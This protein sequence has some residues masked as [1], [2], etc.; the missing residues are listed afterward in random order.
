MANTGSRSGA[1]YGDA[2]ILQYVDK[3]HANHDEALQRAFDAPKQEGMPEIQLMPSEA[4][5]LAW[6]MKLVAARRVVELGTLAGYSAIQMAQSLTA[7]GKLWTIDAEPRHADV[8]RANVIAAGLSA[9]VEVL[10]GRGIDMLPTVEAHGPFDA[11][12]I[13]ADK[14]GYP[15]YGRWAQ[16][17]H[18]SGGLMIADNVFLFGE[19][20]GESDDAAAM[21]RFHEESAAAFDTACIATPDGLLVARKP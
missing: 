10:V 5:L 20:L 14:G 21:R 11:V 15:D 3:V 2:Q 1:H 4:R 8:A 6:L 18:R 16:S 9:K 13:D 19:L 7:D 17:N 12:F